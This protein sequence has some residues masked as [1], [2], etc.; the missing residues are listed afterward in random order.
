MRTPATLGLAVALTG[1]L[2]TG[3]LRRAE[4]R[5]PV[6]APPA[7]RPV[8]ATYHPAPAPA[9]PPVQRVESASPPRTL[10]VVATAAR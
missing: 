10:L 9:P 1:G 8:P 5:A 2:A 7:R 6:V 3:Y 4:P